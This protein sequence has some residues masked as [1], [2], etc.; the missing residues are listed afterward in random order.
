MCIVACLRPRNGLKRDFPMPFSWVGWM[1]RSHT[2]HVALGLK[3]NST[4]IQHLMYCKLLCN[5]ITL[6]GKQFNL[7]L[8]IF[9]RFCYTFF[10]ISS[11]LHWSHNASTHSLT[12]SHPA[13]SIKSPRICIA[14]SAYKF[15]IV[16]NEGGCVHKPSAFMECLLK[17]QHDES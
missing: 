9:Y 11:R 1:S 5:V 4:S 16:D 13:K 8:P 2:P 7:K 10:A 12:L 15:D 6:S 14:I 17:G 3:I